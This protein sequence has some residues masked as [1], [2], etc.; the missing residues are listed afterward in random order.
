MI[1]TL[2]KISKY[3]IIFC[4]IGYLS[5][6]FFLRTLPAPKTI[7]PALDNEPV[8]SATE[9]EPLS[10]EYRGKNYLVKPLAEYELWGL[11]V[12]HNDINKWY[13][14]YHDKDSVNIKDLCVIWGE[15]IRS[16]VY[17]KMKFDSGEW[18]CYPKRDSSMDSD[19]A[20]LY[21]LWQLSNNHLLSSDEEVRRVINEARVGDQIHF[22]GALVSYGQAGTPEQYYRASSLTRKDY[23][24]EVVLVDEMEILKKGLVWQYELKKWSIIIFLFLILFKITLFIIANRKYLFAKRQ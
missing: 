22:K 19:T 8:Q 17:Q 15:N 18:T 10:F 6:I 16:Q 2:R 3:G 7:L 14:F 21:N 5:A 4:I 9:R 1:E 23:G 24:C 11:V 20:R 13:N 12:S